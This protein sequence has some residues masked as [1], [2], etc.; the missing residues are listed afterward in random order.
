[1]MKWWTVTGLRNDSLLYVTE[2]NHVYRKNREENGKIYLICFFGREVPT[3]MPEDVP[4]RN[5]ND[6]CKGKVIICVLMLCNIVPIPKLYTHRSYHKSVSAT[7]FIRNGNFQQ[8]KQHDHNA[9]PSN[10]KLLEYLRIVQE[11][12]EDGE[13]DIDIN[14]FETR[15]GNTKPAISYYKSDEVSCQ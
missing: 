4:R 6:L 12:R 8:R 5:P 11:Y 9:N 15:F 2:D 13:E 3:R 14:N 7:G 10:E 1:M